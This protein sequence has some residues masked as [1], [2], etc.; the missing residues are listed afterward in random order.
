MPKGVQILWDT[1]YNPAAGAHPNFPTLVP[2][3]SSFSI[4][5]IPFFFFFSSYLLA[6]LILPI[7]AGLDAARWRRRPTVPVLALLLVLVWYYGLVVRPFETPTN[8]VITTITHRHHQPLPSRQHQLPPETLAKD[9][10]HLRKYLKTSQFTYAQRL[11]AA[12]PSGG[13]REQLGVGGVEPLFPHAETLDNPR[14]DPAT[15]SAASKININDINIRKISSLP[16]LQLAV[17][18]SPDTNTSIISFGVATS[19]SRLH[20]ASLQ[21]VHWLKDAGAPLLVISTPDDHVYS[22]QSYLRDL[23]IAATIETSQDR[24]PLAFFSLIKRLYETRKPHTQWLALIDDDTFIPS[25]PS[26]VDHLSSTYRADREVMVTAMSDNIEQ[27]E[28][29]GM[30]AFGGGGIFIS[31]PLAARLAKPT[32]W[33]KCLQLAESRNQGDQIVSHCLNNH[34]DIRPVFDPGLHQMDIMGGTDTPA[35][36]FESGRRMLTVHHWRTWFKVDIPKG[37]LVSKACGA[38]GLFQRWSFPKSN[39]VLSNGFSIVEYPTGLDAID[40]AA[41]EKTWKGDESKF[42]HKIGPLREPLTSADKTSYR[43]V[44]SEVVGDWF[45]RQTYIHRG[46]RLDNDEAEMDQVL[47]L[48]WLL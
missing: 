9:L 37:L 3:L 34:T 35:G 36:Y 46:I 12:K 31:V 43:L 41:V 39:M 16:P 27:I 22:M 33:E 8:T 38:E 4:T 40:F 24:T 32:V 10:Q 30:Q 18:V 17:P 48:L 2:S 20:E 26:L 6:A 13:E 5:I 11:V 23:G 47:E 15:D 25:L 14:D 29:W 28:E 1:T 19:V 44:D 42:L 21:F 45:V 7:M